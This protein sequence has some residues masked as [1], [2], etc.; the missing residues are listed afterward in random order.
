ML[1]VINVAG[2]DVGL[3]SVTLNCDV[4]YTACCSAFNMHVHV[5]ALGNVYVA[6]SSKGEKRVPDASKLGLIS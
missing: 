6:K 2:L 5:M 3:R 4:S 1:N